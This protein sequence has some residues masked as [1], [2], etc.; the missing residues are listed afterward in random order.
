MPEQP[1]WDRLLSELEET[2]PKRER[3]LVHRFC[4][5]LLE[6]NTHINLVSRT[7]TKNLIDQLVLDSL[8][9]LPLIDYPQKAL[10]LDIGSGA[11]FP[12]ILH[13]IVRSDLRIISVDSNRRKIEFQRNASRLLEFSDCKFIAERIEQLEPLDTDFAIAKAVGP[14]NLICNLAGPHLKRSGKLILPRGTDETAPDSLPGF[15]LVKSSNYQGAPEAR[16]S[17]LIILEKI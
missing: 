5:Y 14:I 4:D 7:D 6:V 16:L 1:C 10:L 2:D 11:G 9:M 3:E 15:A 8:A 13:K 12:W 17:T